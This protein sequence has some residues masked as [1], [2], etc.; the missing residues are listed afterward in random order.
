MPEPRV[1]HPAKAGAGTG[2]GQRGQARR[3]RLHLVEPRTD[4]FAGEAPEDVR[5]GPAPLGRVTLC[6]TTPMHGL[7]I[8]SE[9]EWG[10]LTTRRC[11]RCTALVRPSDSIEE[12]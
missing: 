5:R 6:G 3:S 9:V 4:L 8:V 10:I 7:V 12:P 1:L 11:P 2:R